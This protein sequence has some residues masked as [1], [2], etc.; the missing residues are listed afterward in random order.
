MEGLLNEENEWDSNFN[1]EK[2]EGPMCK[3]GKDET[4][5]KMKRGKASG[6]RV[7]SE[8]FK[9]SDDLGIEWSMNLANCHRSRVVKVASYL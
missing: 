9:G 2:V 3:F 1:C 4:V 8:M 6:L 5:K 7:V